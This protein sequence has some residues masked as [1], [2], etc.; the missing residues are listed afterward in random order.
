MEWKR[1]WPWT[2]AQ[3]HS[4]LLENESCFSSFDQNRPIE[5]YEF[6]SFDTEL[7]GLNPRQ[8]QIVSIGAVRIRNLRIVAGENFFSYVHP[9]RELPKDSTLIH[10]ITPEQIKNAPE[11]DSVLPDFVRFCGESLL[12][13]HYVSLDMA[14]LNKAARKILGGVLRNP[15]VDSMRLAQAHQEYRRRNHYKRFNPGLSFNLSVLARE[16]DLPLFVQ[17][18]ALE[19][20]LQTAY[21]FIYLVKKLRRAGYITLKDFYL[22]G[23]IGPR[24]F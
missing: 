8:D 7:T 10:R 23:R 3:K 18:D 6:I 2:R 24:M 11:L 17:H 9:T 4:V 1:F 19:D 15:C 22:A 12:V 13:G 5:S 14:F 21:L 16:Y 20:A